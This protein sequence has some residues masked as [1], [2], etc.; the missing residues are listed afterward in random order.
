MYITVGLGISFNSAVYSAAVGFTKQLGP[1]S[2][3]L[4]PLVGIFIGFGEIISKCLK[5]LV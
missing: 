2:M 5:I 1:E 4:V 3:E